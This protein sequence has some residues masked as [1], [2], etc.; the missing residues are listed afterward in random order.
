[1]PPCSVIPELVYDDVREAVR[2]LTDTF[3][4]RTRWT[5]GEHR[6]QLAI[7]DGGLAVTEARTGTGYA[8]QPDAVDYRAPRDGAVSHGIMVRVDD[9]DT[10]FARAR[11]HGRAS[12]MNR[13]TTPTESASTRSKTWAATAGRSR[14]QSPTSRLKNGAASL[15]RRAPEQRVG[16]SDA[17]QRASRRRNPLRALRLHT[18]AFPGGADAACRATPAR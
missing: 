6:A 15:R 11:A 8:D 16:G 13:P 12:C 18:G 7:G 4:F 14:R 9:V 3:G 5:A 1:M 2:W 17:P 10:H